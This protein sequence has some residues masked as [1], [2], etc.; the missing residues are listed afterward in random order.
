MKRNDMENPF[1][2]GLSQQRENVSVFFESYLIS[3]AECFGQVTQ[4]VFGWKQKWEKEGCL[5]LY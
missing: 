1:F 4:C 2:Q 3:T 5:A